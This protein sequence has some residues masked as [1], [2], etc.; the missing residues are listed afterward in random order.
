[1]ED[2]PALIST[3]R[4]HANHLSQPAAQGYCDASDRFRDVETMYILSSEDGVFPDGGRPVRGWE[5]ESLRKGARTMLIDV[6]QSGLPFSGRTFVVTGGTSG[7]GRATADVL[8]SRGAQVAVIGRSS[9]RAEQ[10]AAACGALPIVA[11]VGDEQSMMRAFAQVDVELGPID[12]LFANAGVMP[13]EEPIHE[14]SIAV[15][16]EVIR[17]NLRGMFLCLRE[18]LGRL[19]ARGTGGAVVCTSSVVAA[20]A[21]PGGLN[22][23]AASKGAISS[24]VRQLAVDYAPYAIRV[25][26]LSPGAIETPLAWDNLPP[27]EVES[28]RRTVSDS[29]PLGRIGDPMECG[30]AVAWLLSDEA[31]YVSG[32]ELLVDG[33]VNAMSVV[34]I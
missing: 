15:W 7:I 30:L 13:I 8:C 11:D 28:A 32:A 9:V 34:P 4:S 5:R 23:Y 14:G 10:I 19:V 21:V 25:N 1:M 2:R 24:L 6:N 33:A 12:G 18:A 3:L 26:A 31:S 29:V 20:Q 16:D 27:E 17:V 22:A